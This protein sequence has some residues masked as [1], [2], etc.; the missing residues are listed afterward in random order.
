MVTFLGISMESVSIVTIMVFDWVGDA[1]VNVTIYIA[2][3][4]RPID[5]EHPCPVTISDDHTARVPHDIV[6]MQAT[7][8]SA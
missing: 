6:H 7:H 3:I 8:S 1:V 4:L 5:I 2:Q